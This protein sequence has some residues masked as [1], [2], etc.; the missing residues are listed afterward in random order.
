MV[1]ASG[2]STAMSR[3]LVVDDEAEFR[4]MLGRSLEAEGLEVL[5]APDGP[6][7]LEQLAAAAPELMVLDVVMP[8]MDG[9]GVMAAMRQRGLAPGTRVVMMTC[10]TSERDHVRGWELGADDYL[11][12]PFESEALAER[13]RRLLMSTPET[14]RS[15]RAAELEKAALLDRLEAAMRRPRRPPRPGLLAETA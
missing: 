13:L 2:R 5:Q 8:G 12:K 7:A 3:V 1:A 9:F 10:R 14:L 4:T 15:H 6:A 11:T